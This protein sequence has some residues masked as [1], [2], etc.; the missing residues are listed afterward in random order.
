MASL[1]IGTLL[2]NLSAGL[3]TEVSFSSHLNQMIEKLNKR[4]QEQ[5]HEINKLNET[6]R[7][8]EAKVAEAE[9][10]KAALRGRM[11]RFNADLASR[12]GNAAASAEVIRN[13][14]Q[15]ID[16]K[17]AK[18]DEQK[19]TKVWPP[20]VILMRICRILQRAQA[21]NG[22]VASRHGEYATQ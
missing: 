22:P 11:E 5:D 2:E 18:I 13:L 7:E 20:S 3:G 1:T 4:R 10:D 19:R 14:Q 6:I 16:A 8:M 9:M 15:A 17:Q 21:G 12:D